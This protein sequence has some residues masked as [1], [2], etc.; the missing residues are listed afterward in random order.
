MGQ[1]APG[2]AHCKGLTLLQVADM[3][4]QFR[5]KTVSAGPEER[6]RQDFLRILI[7]DYGYRE[8][9]LETE[10][11]I[12]EA[13]AAETEPTSPSSSRRLDAIRLET[14]SASSRPRNRTS[15]VG[16]RN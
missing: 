12:P 3:V 8:S 5:G 7:D 10:F 1:K 13:R 11:P 4:R 16:S 15:A 2:K 14:S 6:V 9:E